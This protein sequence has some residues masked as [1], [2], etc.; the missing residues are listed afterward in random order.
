MILAAGYGSRLRPL[1]D[2]LPK[3]L[4]PLVNRPLLEYII[5]GIRAAGIQEIALN[6]HYRGAQ[7]RQWLGSGERFGVNVTYSEEP[8]ILGSAGGVRRMRGFFGDGPALVV[9]GDLLFDVDLRAVIQYHLLHAAHATLVLHPAYHRYNYGLVKVNAQ[10]EIA[11]FV[12]QQAPWVAGP[13]IDTVFTGVQ[14]LDP[15]VLDT[16]PAERVAILTTDVYPQL[17]SRRERL[18]GYLMQG[19]WSDVGT[20]HRYWEANLD[21][22]RGLVSPIE[23]RDGSEVQHTTA[24]YSRTIAHPQ[25]QSSVALDP[26]VRI[27]EKASVG[28][29]VVAGEGCEI[30][31]GA[32]VS[33]SILWPRVRIGQGAIIQRSII[34]QDVT[35]PPGSH[36]VGKVVS[37]SGTIAL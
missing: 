12:G 14:V 26:T 6:L 37:A 3:P 19:Y 17:L 7:I 21:L 25:I 34:L 27:G 13:F 33:M 28:P 22:L 23:K 8:E 35:I 24:P 30:A 11:Q 9:H 4:V 1:T 20:P 2:H 29:A 18:Y 10:G 15:V 36:Q 5:G 16:I 31:A 32:H